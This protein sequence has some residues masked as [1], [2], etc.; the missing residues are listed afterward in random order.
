MMDASLALQYFVIAVA[1]IA[2]VAF[3]ARSQ[4]PNAT[5]KLR[6]A[7]AVPLVREHRPAWLR[8]IGRKIAPVP[9]AAGAC[10]GCDK[11]G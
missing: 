10:G 11:C 6:I 4:F 7:L 8:A 5:R 3:V 1:V 2:S 9:K